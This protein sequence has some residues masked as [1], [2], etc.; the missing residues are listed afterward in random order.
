[1]C[2]SACTVYSCPIDKQIVAEFGHEHGE[3][4]AQSLFVGL[5]IEACTMYSVKPR[6]E[7]QPYYDTTI[8]IESSPNLS[9]IPHSNNPHNN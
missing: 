4:T 9:F 3:W 6:H 2:T 8:G 1:M 5:G 7:V